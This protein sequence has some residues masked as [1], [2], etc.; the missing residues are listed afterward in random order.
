MCFLSIA[1]AISICIMTF[2]PGGIE[3]RL[4]TGI[5]L[6]FAILVADIV[7]FIVARIRG[8]QGER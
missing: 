3:F 5:T 2:I 4:S 6:F 8:W 1:F 7:Y